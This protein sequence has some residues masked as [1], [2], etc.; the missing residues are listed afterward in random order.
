MGDYAGDPIWHD[1]IHLPEDNDKP[2]AG[3]FNLVNEPMADRTQYLYQRG[4]LGIYTATSV[5]VGGS[6]TDFPQVAGLAGTWQ[7][8]VDKAGNTYG[9]IPYVDVPNC[10]AGDFL[11]IDATG[12]FYTVGFPGAYGEFRMA[13]VRNYNPGGGV[14]TNLLAGVTST[15]TRTRQ[16]DG[17][18]QERIQL[19]GSIEVDVGGTTRVKLQGRNSLSG[20]SNYVGLWASWS[21]RFTIR[22]VRFRPN[23]PTDFSS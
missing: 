21:D 10:A 17:T 16:Y 15:Q 6:S 4:I 8:I 20:S 3:T 5:L 9:L 2:K 11:L 19:L 13:C 23:N 18:W 22:V 14:G 1:T 12:V 7:D